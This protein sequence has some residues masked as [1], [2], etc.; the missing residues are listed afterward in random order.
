[1]E[2][3]LGRVGGRYGGVGQE[4][5]KVRQEHPFYTTANYK[6]RF[7]GNRS[8]LASDAVL[9]ANLQFSRLKSSQFQALGLS[10]KLHPLFRPVDRFLA[11]RI[12]LFWFICIFSIVKVLYKNTNNFLC[13]LAI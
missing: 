2:G 6:N 7:L 13:V 10:A 1:M 4:G 5:Q 11:F 9:R 3:D 8:D 12:M